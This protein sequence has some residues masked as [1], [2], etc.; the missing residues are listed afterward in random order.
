M[1][2]INPEVDVAM[3]LQTAGQG[4]Y[5]TDIYAPADGELPVDK[6]PTACVLVTC[7]AGGQ[8]RMYFGSISTPK[9]H[10]DYMVRVLVRGE[11]GKAAL[12]LDKTINCMTALHGKTLS[13]YTY[14]LSQQS[15]PVRFPQTGTEQPR[16][17]FILRVGRK[18]IG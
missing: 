6:A 2:T 9:D 10:R 5:G 15:Y 7:M 16:F 13:G 11:Q 17:M 18:V 12:A 4:T 1:T 3:A 14:C 8:P